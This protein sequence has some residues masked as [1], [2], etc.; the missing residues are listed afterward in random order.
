VRYPIAGR[1]NSRFAQSAVAPFAK[2]LHPFCLSRTDLAAYA[3]SI[4]GESHFQR[5]DEVR[6]IH[7]HATALAG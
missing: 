4:E 1:I 6:V 2:Y 7:D 3:L 5:H